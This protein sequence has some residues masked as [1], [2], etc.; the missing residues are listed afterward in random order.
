MKYLAPLLPSL[1]WRYFG[2]ANYI[3]LT[4][5]SIKYQD[6]IKYSIN[7]NSAIGTHGGF[8]W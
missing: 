5:L 7:V 6:A 3:H 2:L 8:E 4:N 1:L